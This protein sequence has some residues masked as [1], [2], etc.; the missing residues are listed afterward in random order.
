MLCPKCGK[1]SN[2]LRVCA[3]CQTPYPT[4]GSAQAAAPRSTRAVVS[5][6]A[7]K[8]APPASKA[9]PPG[10]RTADQRV[11]PARRSR[12]ASWSVIGLLAALTAGFYIVERD[13]DIPVGVAMPN[14]ISRPMT[15]IEATNILKA[16]NGSAQVEV[17]GGDLIVR[18]AAA[19][20]PERRDGQLALAQQYTR[21]DA[22]IQGRRRKISFFDPGGIS[23][24][25]ADPDK[26]VTLTR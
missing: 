20:Y 5:A 13:R 14:L 7:P 22:I 10:R 18:I 24:A 19:T 6:P 21:A 4:D 3:F 16:I 12:I 8:A 15:P 26:G 2:N 25:S 9:P 1:E 11:A 23:F 17:R